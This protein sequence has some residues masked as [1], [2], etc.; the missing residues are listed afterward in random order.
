MRDVITIFAAGTL[1][2]AYALL[3]PTIVGAVQRPAPGAH[4]AFVQRLVQVPDEAPIS[5]VSGPVM[6]GMSTAGSALPW[7]ARY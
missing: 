3:A 1:M 5:V 6:D 7:F 2:T 4:K